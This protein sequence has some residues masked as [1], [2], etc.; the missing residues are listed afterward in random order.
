MR[1]ALITTCYQ[2]SEAIGAFMDAILAQTRQPDEIIVV[3]AGSDDGTVEQIQKR[4]D[5][6]APIKLILESG[7]NRSRG[8]NRAIEES[9][10]EL[11]A[12]T[13]VGAEPRRDWFERI[14]A[15]L[16]EGGAPHARQE[17]RAYVTG[18]TPVARVDVVAGYYEA[19]P[20][21]LWEAAVA[22][23]TV[24]TAKEVDPESF[25]PSARSVAFRKRAW[26]KAGRYPEWAWHNED[27]PF[28]L[29]LK[30]SG[31]RFVFEPEAVVEWRPRASL[32]G[33]FVQFWRY[34][35]GDAQARIWFRH[36]TKAYLVTG[37][38]LGLLVLSIFWP[39]ALTG[40]VMLGLAYWSRH[41]LRASRRTSSDTAPLL[42]PLANMIVDVAHVAGYTR[43]LLERGAHATGE[44]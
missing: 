26:E 5:E 13:D 38:T 40:S 7:A 6:G 14:V 25:L 43:G 34:A 36:Y 15:P 22:T 21:T 41:A 28:D 4:V 39:P 3:D 12:V 33:L 32:R 2:E 17:C 27:T 9:A 24:P 19:R 16:E 23:A 11:I 1:T 18:Q 29:A 44:D 10:A 35:R 31:A 37:L 42:A 30:E 8:R 20:S